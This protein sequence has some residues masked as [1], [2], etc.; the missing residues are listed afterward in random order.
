MTIILI[1]TLKTLKYTNTSA[2]ASLIEESLSAN[3]GV[4][5]KCYYAMRYWNPYTEEVLEKMKNDGVN[6][7]VIAPLYVLRICSILPWLSYSISSG[8]LGSK[9]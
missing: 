4:S 6:T 5:A 7:V 3:H 1:N 2:Q 9:P 8:A